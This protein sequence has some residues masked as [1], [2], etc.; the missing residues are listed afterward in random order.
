MIRRAV[1]SF[2]ALHS[3]CAYH[4]FIPAGHTRALNDPPEFDETFGYEATTLASLY[5]ETPTVSSEFITVDTTSTTEALATEALTIETTTSVTQPSTTQ[6]SP[7]TTNEYSWIPDSLRFI[8]PLSPNLRPHDIVLFSGGHSA[9][10]R[11][12]GFAKLSADS[13]MAFAKH[14]GYNCVFL[15]QLNYDRSL[16]LNGIKF[17]DHWHR[18]FAMPDLRKRFPDAK[19]FV[20]FDDDILVP[21]VETH[22]LNHYVNLMEADD[23]WQM[24]YGEEGADY[25][26]NSGMFIMKNTDFS[27]D[28]YRRAI[29]IGLEKDGHLARNFGHEQGAI[30]KV[31]KRGSLSH[32]IRIIRHRDGPYNFNNF[33]RDAGH[34]RPGTRAQFGDAFVHFTGLDGDIRGDLMGRL[35]RM[36]AIWRISNP[37][38]LSYPVNDYTG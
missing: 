24:L 7:C 20:W 25:V 9:S 1:I 35:I 19:Y 32:R 27:F 14:H 16:L 10:R 31:R 13:I 12:H 37:R 15:D 33:E 6:T 28:A 30:I 11:M 36:V 4:R 38:C 8:E 23:A 5:N 3:I 2:L 18:V 21:F 29:R 22:M 17:T 34:D 26:L